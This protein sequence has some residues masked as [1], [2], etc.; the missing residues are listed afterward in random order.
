M[1]FLIEHIVWMNLLWISVEPDEFSWGLL[2]AY[3]GIL[4]ASVAWVMEVVVPVEPDPFDLHGQ[5]CIVFVVGCF[6]NL[7]ASVVV[8]PGSGQGLGDAYRY[9]IAFLGIASVLV[10]MLWYLLRIVKA[11]FSNEPAL[12]LSSYVLYLGA[13]WVGINGSRAT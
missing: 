3:T 9:V 13:L 8:L 5:F 12:E 7:N 1:L 11:G 4:I 10:A 2:L 6:V